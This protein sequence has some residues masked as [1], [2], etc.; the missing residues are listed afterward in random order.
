MVC[1]V[2]IGR[3]LSVCVCIDMYLR[4]LTCTGKHWYVRYVLQIF[5]N[6]HY[7]WYA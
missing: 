7:C 6:I 5:E 3:Y 1:I 2:R 4:V